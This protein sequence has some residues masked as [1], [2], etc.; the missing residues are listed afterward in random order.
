MPVQN[1]NSCSQC[2][3]DAA[4]TVRPIRLTIDIMLLTG[5][6]STPVICYSK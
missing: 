4:P 3:Y 2:V 6:R 1:L 5:A